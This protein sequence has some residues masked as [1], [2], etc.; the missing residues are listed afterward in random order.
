VT[1]E[2]ILMNNVSLNSGIWGDS[3]YLRSDSGPSLSLCVLFVKLTGQVR[4]ESSV[5][6]GPTSIFLLGAALLRN[7]R[8]FKSYPPVS[9]RS[10]QPENV[11][12][13]IRCVLQN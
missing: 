11:I 3:C 13:S 4:G 6:S 9:F 8:I 10:I 5:H 2:A 12:Y 7:A 1:V